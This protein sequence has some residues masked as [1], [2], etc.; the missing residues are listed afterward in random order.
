MARGVLRDQG[1]TVQ[2]RE[3]DHQQGLHYYLF[4]KLINCLRVT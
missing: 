3:R 2:N 4:R 1:G